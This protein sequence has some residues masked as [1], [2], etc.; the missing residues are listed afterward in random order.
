MD[1]IE[2]FE[3][4]RLEVEAMFKKYDAL[5]D[6]AIKS[7][8]RLLGQIA[9]ALAMHATIEEKDRRRHAVDDEEDRSKR[10]AA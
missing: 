2:M 4:Q 7:K 9:D 3:Q 5:G 8:L 1:A 10:R 6:K